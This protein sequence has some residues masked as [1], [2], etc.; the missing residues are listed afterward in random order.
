MSDFKLSILIG[1]ILL[2]G[3]NFILA[4]TIILDFRGEPSYNQVTLKWTSENEIN[5]KGFEIERGFNEHDFK[6]I[7]FV[8]ASDDQKQRKEYTYDDRS[9]F[10]AS[11]REFYYRLK[12]VDLD[13]TVTYS[14][15]IKVAATVSSA[16]LTWGSI[17]AMFR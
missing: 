12:I 15:H 7:G 16:R 1:S 5:L 6:M 11:S 10:K 13:N 9:V 14:K 4:G 8:K 3:V 2:F 17:K